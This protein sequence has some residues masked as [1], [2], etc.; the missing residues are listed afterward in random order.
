MLVRAWGSLFPMIDPFHFFQNLQ[1][2]WFSWNNASTNQFFLIFETPFELLSFFRI[3]H[4]E[5]SGEKP[6]LWRI[7][8]PFLRFF[9][10]HPGEKPKRDASPQHACSANEINKIIGT[11]WSRNNRNKR[12]LK[13]NILIHYHLELFFNWIQR[14]SLHLSEF[15]FF[16]HS[17]LHIEKKT[18]KVLLKI[19]FRC[20]KRRT[21][22]TTFSV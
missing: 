15:D 14:S 4:R 7:Y 16:F 3:L 22:N 12:F 11:A 5:R 9:T 13:K 18:R 1:E 21:K 17:D 19:Y 20:S 2:I 8:I 6:E 10:F